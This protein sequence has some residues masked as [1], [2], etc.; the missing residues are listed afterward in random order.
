[1]TDTSKLLGAVA[2]L[3]AKVNALLATTDPVEQKQVDD[4][5]ARVIALQDRVD[6]ATPKGKP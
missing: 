3:E 6:K 4:A 2:A 1:M 5:T